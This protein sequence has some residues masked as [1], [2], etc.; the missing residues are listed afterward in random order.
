MVNLNTNISNIQQ[1][2]S[3]YLQNNPSYTSYSLDKLSE[4]LLKN[5]V[6]SDKEVALLKTTPLLAFSST[7]EDSPWGNSLSLG[8][9]N[10]SA[11]SQDN[12]ELEE[13]VVSLNPV[14]IL[15]DLRIIED[16]PPQWLTPT[17]DLLMSSKN[18]VDLSQFDIT[19]LQKKYPSERYDIKSLPG[20]ENTSTII[21]IDK[22]T[23]S[24]V[25]VISM[26]SE[27]IEITEHV[28]NPKRD[29]T[30]RVDSQTGKVLTY[31]YSQY[32]EN[33]NRITFEYNAD[34]NSLLSQRFQNENELGVVCYDSDGKISSEYYLKSGNKGVGILE[35]VFSNVYKQGVLV[36]SER[37]GKIAFPLMDDFAISV[38]KIKFIS[39]SA[40]M[41]A[42]NLYEYEN[43]DILLSF[44]KDQEDI[45]PMLEYYE[46]RYWSPLI[47]DLRLLAKCE[48]P[49]AAKCRELIKILEP[50]LLKSG[51][52]GGKY[53]AY[54]L[55]LALEAKDKTLLLSTLEKVD[56]AHMHTLMPMIAFETSLT[57]EFYEANVLADSQNADVVPE[58]LE[59]INN[60]YD[61]LPAGLLGA[62]KSAE[63]LTEEEKT[64]A[65]TTLVNKVLDALPADDK[66]EFIKD[67]QSHPNDYVKLDIDILRALNRVNST[68]RE[69]SNDR[70]TEVSA[71][72]GKFD[73]PSIQGTEGDCWL[74]AGV[75]AII[76]KSNGKQMLE[77]LF[78]VDKETGN[79]TITLKGIG[80]TYT[81]TREEIENADHLSSGDGDMR[82]LE[83]AIDKCLKELAY[84]QSYIQLTQCGFGA[85][86]E[87]DLDLH[88]GNS[89]DLYSLLF[90][91]GSP[92][93]NVDVMATDFS[94]ENSVYVFSLD[95]HG[96]G[97]EGT[98][99][100]YAYNENGEKVVLHNRHGY[101]IVG[102]D[103]ENV[104]ITNPWDPTEVLTISRV[105]FE[106]IPKR[107]KGYSFNA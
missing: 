36:Y 19:H 50:K 58:Y 105:E 96:I 64:Q 79:V 65:I 87:H 49:D 72:D 84:D 2:V 52:H 61:N 20:F 31:E 21:I 42:T 63:F 26:N 71:P 97:F 45:I 56:L 95:E 7:S 77:S 51:E 44:V 10:Y 23:G 98:T 106:Q 78:T 1:K 54:D 38:D 9:S 100:Y 82:A 24:N 55:Q 5:G 104:Y 53:L 46:E 92:I 74:L 17:G 30:R 25:L 14:D 88:S 85:S 34:D 22:A 3:A 62:I 103:D 89:S 39:G 93:V 15:K 13:P 32:D 37:E 66:A 102:S 18:Q 27:A 6:L 48:G 16:K 41:G 101:S 12:V 67:M 43:I 68:S 86:L 73:I 8:H 28:G 107:V 35:P 80:K 94:D 69:N 99:E 83:L 59:Y 4:I 75:N 70:N 40:E 29:I 60:F 11:T 91:G 81:I 90:E 47:E 57:K 76:S 33:H